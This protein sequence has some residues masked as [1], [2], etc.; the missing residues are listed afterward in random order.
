MRLSTQKPV[1]GLV[2]Q[3]AL[4]QGPLAQRAVSGMPYE[5]PGGKVQGAAR[6][7]LIAVRFRPDVSRL[8]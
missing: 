6:A 1:A 3:Q 8:W 5:G 2:V 4:T 7:G